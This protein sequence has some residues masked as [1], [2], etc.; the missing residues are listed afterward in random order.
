MRNYYRTNII[1]V[2]IITIIVLIG[3]YKVFLGHNFWFYM[4]QL[5]IS[6]WSYGNSLG[7]GW[8]PDIGFGSSFFYADP[9]W[10]P[11]SLEVFWQ[12][13]VSSRAIEYSSIVI[14]HSVL[15]AIAVFFL[16]KQVIPDLSPLISSLLAPL[17][18]FTVSMD[19]VIANQHN[20]VVLFIVP[21]M[22]ILLHDYY[23][24]P[25]LVHFFLVSLLFWYSLAFGFYGNWIHFP[26]L[27]L[28]FTILYCFYKKESFRKLILQYLL[29]L[30]IGSL[31]AVILGFWEFYSIYLEKS[32]IEFS[33]SK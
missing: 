23:K 25:K 28:V 12:M 15:P 18:V 21:L 6:N 33:R 4:D 8:R 7:N 16:L 19:S 32:L 22:L 26:S 31:I 1:P 30:S 13:L 14:F 9:A 5:A 2:V 20:S 11:W 17:I 29:I 3:F 24:S 27:G 10:H